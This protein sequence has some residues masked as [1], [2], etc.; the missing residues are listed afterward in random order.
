MMQDNLNK[1]LLLLD[2]KIVCLET[3]LSLTSEQKIAIDN[4][5][6]ENLESFLDKKD[7]IIKEIDEID[8]IFDDN[9]S[10]E[11]LQDKILKS[12]LN[13]IQSLLKNIK[14]I[15]DDN[16]NNLSKAIDENKHRLKDVRHGQRAMKGYSNSDPYASFASQG[17]T[18]F[19][20]QDS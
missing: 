2:K 1:L 9:K 5:D 6:V 10:E 18:L 19:I 7:I 13:N 11:L 17:G 12:K 16:N 15:D 4:D 20:D 8:S 14:L 3:M